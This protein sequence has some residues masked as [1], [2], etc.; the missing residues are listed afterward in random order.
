[1]SPSGK[2]VIADSIYDSGSPSYTVAGGF[3]GASVVSP[4]KS[5]TS[6]VYNSGQRI[7]RARHGGKANFILCDGHVEA[8][9][10]NVLRAENNMKNATTKSTL[11]WCGGI[12]N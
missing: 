7:D 12:I 3:G 10:E 1:M 8:I 2:A 5:G 6:Q 4:T 11:L 9:P